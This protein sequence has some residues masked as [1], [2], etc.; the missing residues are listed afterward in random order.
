VFAPQTHG[1]VIAETAVGQFLDLGSAMLAG[2]GVIAS[3]VEVFS[4]HSRLRRNTVCSCG[5][6]ERKELQHS[7]PRRLLP[8]PSFIGNVAESERGLRI[9]ARRG[10]S[11]LRDWPPV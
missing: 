2:K 10:P 6:L 3:A 1:T 7:S 9:C 5:E 8:A 4:F 11:P